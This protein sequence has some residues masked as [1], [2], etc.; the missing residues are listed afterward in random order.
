VCPASAINYDLS[1]ADVENLLAGF[2][3]GTL[4][5]ELKLRITDLRD[6]PADCRAHLSQ[7]QAS[8]RAWIAWATSDGP[9]AAWGDYHLEPSKRLF[10]YLLSVEWWTGLTGHHSLWCYCEPKRPT[11]WTIGRTRP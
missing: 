2:L 3:E 4:N 1:R 10:G 7:A 6:L 9:M 5:V 11:E 8:N